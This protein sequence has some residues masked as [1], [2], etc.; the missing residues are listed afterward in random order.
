MLKM[1]FFQIIIII[2]KKSEAHKIFVFAPIMIMTAFDSA[3]VQKSHS[4]ALTGY[5]QTVHEL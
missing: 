2:I 3:S 1:Y 5:L 4:V